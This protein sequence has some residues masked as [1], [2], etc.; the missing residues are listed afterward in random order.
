MKNR[1]IEFFNLSFLDLLSGALAAIIFLFIIVPKGNVTVIET[2]LAV[3]FD[4]IQSKFFGDIP[5][6][7]AELREGDTLLAI[8]TGY[9]DSPVEVSSPKPLP[10]PS[11]KPTARKAPMPPKSKTTEAEPE[12]PRPEPAT[13]R[14]KPSEL[15]G[16]RPNVPCVVSFEAKWDHKEDNVDLFVCKD[17]ECVFGAPRARSNSSIGYWDS[18]KSRTKLFGSDLRTNQEAVRQFDD[19]IPG[20]Y[21]IFLQYKN[22]DNPKSPLPVQVQVYTKNPDGAERGNVHHLTLTLDPHN[23]VPAARATI[24]SDG[25][26]EFQPIN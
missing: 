9:Y 20:V 23:R 21:E 14:V 2:P 24:G 1:E 8:I 22:S 10:T 18:G 25:E 13:P 7:L 11:P 6:S 17:G 5:E 4:T 3:S 15:V 12:E 26:I 19:I 16:S